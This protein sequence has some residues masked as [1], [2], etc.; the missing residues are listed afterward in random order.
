MPRAVLVTGAPCSGKN[1]YVD[2]N[3]RQ[4]DLIVD[5]DALM[6]AFTGGALH[7]HTKE[8]RRYVWEARDVV[9]RKWMARRDVDIWVIN[10]APK[11]AMR[12]FYRRNGFDVITMTASLETCLARAR[13]ERPPEW[14]D[15]IRRY[16]KDFQP[17]DE[18]APVPQAS[19]SKR[20]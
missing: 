13:M 18:A 6:L 19:T 7:T 3:S 14:C 17:D 16:F 11:K 8:V 20:W 5:Y 4:G 15:Y 1:V 9:I 2:Q 12:D 10:S